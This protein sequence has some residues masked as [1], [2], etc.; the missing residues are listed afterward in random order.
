[1]SSS[2]CCFLTRMQ[3]SQETSKVV[4]Y[5]HLFKNFPQFFMIHTVKGISTINEAEADVFLEFSFFFYDPTDVGNLISQCVCVCAQSCPT[6]CGLMNGSPPG[7]S[8][9]GI[10]QARILDWGAISYSRGLP[11]SRNG[12]HISWD[13]SLAG[14]F[15][16][17]SAIWEALIINRF[18]HRGAW[19]TTVH[20]VTRS[21]TRLKQLSTQHTEKITGD[22]LHVL[23]PMSHVKERILY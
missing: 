11:Q 9:H 20:G 4:R 21:Q 8:V 19:R 5:S 23:S 13:P 14:R 16:T 22:K 15:F 10:F 7:S 3:I 6:L 18:Q 12:T 2:N 17:T 1:M